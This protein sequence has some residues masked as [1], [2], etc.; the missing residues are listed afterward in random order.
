MFLARSGAVFRLSCE[1][2]TPKKL[3]IDKDR[4]VEFW[5]ENLEFDLRDLQLNQNPA[6]NRVFYLP[7]PRP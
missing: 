4:A 1:I 2:G 5:L 7:S 6:L 3:Y